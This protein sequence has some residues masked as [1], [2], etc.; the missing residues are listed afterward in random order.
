[1]LATV[2][3]GGRG[4]WPTDT[5]VDTPLANLAMGNIFSFYMEH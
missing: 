1:M 4:L 3:P 5:P 2:V